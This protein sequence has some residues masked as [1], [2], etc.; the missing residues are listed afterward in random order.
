MDINVQI[1]DEKIRPIDS[2]EF[3][4]LPN[5]EIRRMSALGKDTMGI[6]NPELYDNMEPKRGGL[7]DTRLGP[8]SSGLNC[9]TCGFDSTNCIGHFGHIELADPVFHIGYIQYV[10]KILSCI[11]LKC[12]KLLI[13][14][15]EEEILELVKH[16]SR[17][18]RFAE[19][20]NVSKNVTHC[21]KPGYGCG[22]PV[23]KIKIETKKTSGAVNIVSELQVQAED[24]EGDAGG[25]KI[26]KQILTPEICYDILKNISDSDCLIMG[27]DPKHSRPEDM[28]HKIFPV[29]PVAIR[30]SAKVDFLESSTKE[31][32]LTHK[33]ADIVKA[34]IRIR[35]FK[36]SVNDTTAKYGADHT[37]LLQYHIYTNFDNESAAVP[38]SEQRNKASKSLSS[39]LKGKEGQLIP[40]SGPQ[41]VAAH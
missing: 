7:I 26:I 25:K 38:K 32:D 10:K 4:I 2:M 29:S 28:I 21:V 27:L 5:E 39:R 1:Y 13:Y 37:H 30:P 19:I 33:L 8:T 15:N 14:K 3:N 18:A 16:K 41:Q 23:T 20:R 24:G 9:T 12:S 40:P 31:D 36:E 34:N 22:T 17:K 6:E 11:C 35:K